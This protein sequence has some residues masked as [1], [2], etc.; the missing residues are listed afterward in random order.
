MFTAHSSPLSALCDAIASS[1][2]STSW[3]C[4]S[5]LRY[6][7]Y[8]FSTVN[9]TYPNINFACLEG[10]VNARY[11]VYFWIGCFF[12]PIKVRIAQVEACSYIVISFLLFLAIS[13]LFVF[14]PSSLSF[15]PSPLP[16]LLLFP[17]YLFNSF[18]VP[19]TVLGSVDRHSST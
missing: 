10:N 6:S 17:I 7:L 13:W 1:R 5:H 12:D 8:R 16:S 14:F 4:W 2:S 19:H 15:H 9:G 18:H 11:C 3:F